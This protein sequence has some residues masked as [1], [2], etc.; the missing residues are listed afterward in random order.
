MDFVWIML[1]LSIAIGLVFLYK[2]IIVNKKYISEK[3]LQIFIMAGVLGFDIL[4]NSKLITSKEGLLSL[5]IGKAL[6]SY[7]DG[8]RNT[9]DNEQDLEDMAYNHI[10]EFC[11]E[12]G[13]IVTE[14]LRTNI[15]QAIKMIIS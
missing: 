11:D 12:N 9:I 6:F 8:I 1:F 14:D 4:E 2:Y 10:M 13:I 5:K 7:I 3:D 15:K